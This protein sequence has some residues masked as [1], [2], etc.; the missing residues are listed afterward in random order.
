MKFEK[1]EDGYFSFLYKVATDYKFRSQEL[2]PFLIM[3]I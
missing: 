1:D 2:Q 3:K